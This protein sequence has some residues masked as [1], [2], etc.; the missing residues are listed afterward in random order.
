[1]GSSKSRN[2]EERKATVL[3]LTTV[4]PISDV[5]IY[6]RECRSISA[7]SK[8]YLLLAGPGDLP[9]RP[10]CDLISLPKPFQRRTLR[11]LQS[12][13]IAIKVGLKYR[14][15]ILHLHDPELLIYG[16][17][18]SRV[19]KQKVI[20]DAHEDSVA[21][22]LEGAKLWMPPIFQSFIANI[23]R[24]LLGQADKNFAGI[25]GA[26]DFICSFYSNPNTFLVG[27][28]T[29]TSDFEGAIPDFKSNQVLFVGAQNDSSLFL[30]VVNA[31][32]ELKQ[33]RLA[34]AGPRN[35]EQLWAE[36]EAVLGERLIGLGYLTPP[37]LVE[38]ISNSA[39]GMVTYKFREYHQT[40]SPTKFYE[41]AAAGLPVVA[42]PIIP[43][44]SL[45]NAAENGLISEGYTS[46]DL[47][48]AISFA[49]EDSS[50]LLEWSVNGRAWSALNGNWAESES[51]LL[52]LYSKLLD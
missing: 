26:T 35:N 52:A 22:I 8:Y 45:V 40:S 47:L 27:N 20:W 7:Q 32:S 30:E 41:F 48:K 31:V 1:M 19:F 23:L 17:I 6:Q 13:F 2:T 25:I 34:V 21:Q 15:D 39:L 12:Q 28:G 51:A 24:W 29:R 46:K 36:A 9:P 16:L 49:L 43:C 4:H 5:R 42:T 33:V 37:G 10:E 44:V 14:P 50:M 38:A 18:M 11:F 3:H